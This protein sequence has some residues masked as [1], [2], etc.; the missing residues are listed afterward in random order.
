LSVTVLQASVEATFEA[1]TGQP[2]AAFV[3]G[4]RAA[5]ASWRSLERE[6]YGATGGA[7]QV[8]SVSLARWYGEQ[9]VA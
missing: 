6:A 7:V 2:L 1:K 3:A 5:G 4:R 8:T 9:E